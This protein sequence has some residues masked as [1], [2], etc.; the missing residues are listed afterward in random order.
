[1][2]EQRASK[3]IN[4]EQI[5]LKISGLKLLTNVIGMMRLP[6]AILFLISLVM[7]YTYNVPTPT[8]TLLILPVYKIVIVIFSALITYRNK[9]T[10]IYT[11]KITV[12]NSALI[13]GIFTFTL[14]ISIVQQL[15]SMLFNFSNI[16]AYSYYI[17]MLSSIITLFL[18]KIDLVIKVSSSII[19]ITTIDWI[20]YSVIKYRDTAIFLSKQDGLVLLN[21]LIIATL[22]VALSCY[23]VKLLHRIFT[24]YVLREAKL[25]H[26]KAIAETDAL[27]EISNRRAFDLDIELLSTAHV[28]TVAI[29]M[30]DID[31]FKK[32]NDE[33]GHDIGD[34]VLKQVG[35]L[36]SIFNDRNGVEAY[37]YGGEEMA[38]V[39]SYADHPNNI[40][41]QIE[42]FRSTVSNIKIPNVKRKITISAGLAISNID[43]I[44]KGEER[45]EVLLKLLK[46]ADTNLYKA[47]DTGK[48]KLC[49]T[50]FNVNDII[51]K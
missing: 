13:Y 51:S 46:E 27:T 24:L 48:N 12:L 18:L 28:K 42:L 29:A 11:H 23:A 6:V 14:L 25:K 26:Y 16:G 2:I 41:E 15:C 39:F 9:Q 49:I 20:V 35:R 47:K 22:S 30:L 3:D 1:M 44:R 19:I 32:F 8:A 38:I 31:D 50:K 34:N 17:L 43:T 4:K 5:D 40:E 45:K 36:I 7:I 37:R 10:A 33:Y 21:S